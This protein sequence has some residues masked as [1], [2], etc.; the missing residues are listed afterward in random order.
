MTVEVDDEL[1]DFVVDEIAVE[2]NSSG[3]SVVTSGRYTC[4]VGI[5]EVTGS[6]R[7]ARQ[8]ANR[9]IGGFNPKNS[10]IEGLGQCFHHRLEMREE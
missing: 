2:V 9:S 10:R 1:I 3:D 6:A 7:I 8:I 4:S 5:H